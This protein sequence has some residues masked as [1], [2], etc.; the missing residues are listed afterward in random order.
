MT[1]PTINISL[2]ESLTLTK[3]T[4]IIRLAMDFPKRWEFMQ[5]ANKENSILGVM[6]IATDYVN[7]D[8]PKMEM[9]LKFEDMD[10]VDITI[11]FSELYSQ[12]WGDEL[13]HIWGML[14]NVDRFDC[15]VEIYI[16]RK[17]PT[18]SNAICVEYMQLNPGISFL[19]W[20][21]NKYPDSYEEIKEKWEK[22][23]NKN[24]LL[25]KS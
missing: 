23:I 10:S 8:I 16:K 13:E 24:T 18:S 14:D 12:G 1:K 15:E 3:F 2:D 6:E 9:V 25:S 5:K 22:K 19:D 7:F 17:I 21:L 4:E 11:L 20:V